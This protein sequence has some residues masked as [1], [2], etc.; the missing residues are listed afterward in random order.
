[1]RRRAGALEAGAPGEG[2]F[3]GSR[4]PSLL[5]QGGHRKAVA[6]WLRLAQ[7]LPLAPCLGPR[8]WTRPRGD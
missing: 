1:M 2:L 3:A 4:P 6:Q 8:G 5:L 7:C